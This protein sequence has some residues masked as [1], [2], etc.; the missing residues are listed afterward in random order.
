MDDAD[1]HHEGRQ[2]AVID[3]LEGDLAVVLVGEEETEDHLPVGS[4]PDGAAEGSWLWVERD[5]GSLVVIGL[6]SEGGHA[7]Q[8]RIEERMARLREQGDT[9]RF[10]RS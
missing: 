9:G 1:T 5:Q 6:D 10:D 8:R 4:L 2:R 7:Q 3:R